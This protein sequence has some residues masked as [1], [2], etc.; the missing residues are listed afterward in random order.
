[1]RPPGHSG[2]AKQGHLCFDASFETGEMENYSGGHGWNPTRFN[3]AVF[4]FFFQVTLEEWTSSPKMSEKFL[5][6]LL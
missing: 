1:M 2:K 4:N 6:S 3:V 5:L